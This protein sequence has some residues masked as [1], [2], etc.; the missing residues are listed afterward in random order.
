MRGVNGV[1]MKLEPGISY[2]SHREE[3]INP[4]KKFHLYLCNHIVFFINS[5]K[6]LYEFS[7]NLEKEDCVLFTKDCYLQVK[8][9]YKFDAR[10]RIIRTS[11]MSTQALQRLASYL[12]DSTLK[13]AIP[14]KIADRAIGILEQC[15]LK[16]QKVAK[17]HE[18]K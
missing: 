1:L 12:K 8:T 7:I 10:Q 5:K 15:L 4:K 14:K 17:M 3:I 13:K 18:S 9:V 6:D 11:E 2:L 16:G